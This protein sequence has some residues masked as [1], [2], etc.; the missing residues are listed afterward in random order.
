MKIILNEKPKKIEA[1]EYTFNGYTIIKDWCGTEWMVYETGN[2]DCLIRW[3][4][5]KNQAISFLTF[6]GLLDRPNKSTRK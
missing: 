1:G 4:D 2:D 5:T 3:F 6:D